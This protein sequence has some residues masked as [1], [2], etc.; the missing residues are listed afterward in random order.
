[1]NISFYPG[2]STVYKE[3][4]NYV[5]EAYDKGILSINHRSESFAQILRKTI[6]LLKDK[7]LIPDDYTIMF[8]SSATECWE[9]IAQSLLRKESFHIYN[10][11]FGKK[12][13]EYTKKIRPDTRRKE[14]GIDQNIDVSDLQIPFSSEFICITQNETSNGTEVNLET[15][16]EIQKNYP[17]KLLAI[18]ATSSIAGSFLDF[19]L[20]D[21]WLGS[22]QKCFGLPA[23][24]GILICSPKGIQKALE[25]NECNHYNSLPFVYSN[26]Q[27][28]QTHY[29]PNVLGIFLLSKV[30][31]S[32]PN[33]KEVDQRLLLRNNRISTLLENMKGLEFLCNNPSVRSKTVL[34]IKGE[35]RLIFKLKEEAKDQGISLGNGYGSFKDSTFRIANFPAIPDEHFDLLEKFFVGQPRDL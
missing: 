17:D 15:L 12:W 22:V 35:P 4:P 13:F 6:S 34:T 31:E 33:I 27:K 23:G 3:V 25:I 24:L 8:T 10:G 2:P 11:E 9:I 5:Q 20:A 7:L 21:I 32:V 28:F 14:F 1:M 19:K 30:M 29:T 18:D 16:K 26:I